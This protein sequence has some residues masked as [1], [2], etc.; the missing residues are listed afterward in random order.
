MA[1]KSKNEDLIKKCADMLTLMNI[2]WVTIG[3]DNHQKLIR[4][5]NSWYRKTSLKCLP[6]EVQ[7]L[8]PQ[9]LD[10]MKKVN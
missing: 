5:V 1:S 8:D 2:D 4:H 7:A 9:S 3:L 6:D 10:K